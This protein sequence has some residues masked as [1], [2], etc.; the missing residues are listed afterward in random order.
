MSRLE[1]WLLNG[2]SAVLIALLLAHLFLSR[3][4][5]QLGGQLNSQRGYINN[6]R[7]LQPVL[8]NLVRRIAAAGESDPKLKALLAKYDI[9]LNLPAEQT[10][11]QEQ[12]GK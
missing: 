9:K 7:Q 5:N 8:E 3:A 1:F 12:I 4:N 6:A 2:A 11:P 10:S